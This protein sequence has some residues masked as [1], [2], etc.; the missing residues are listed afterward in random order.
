MESLG[1][2][3]ARI[4]G[5]T[6]TKPQIRT[7]LGQ[8][9]YCRHL[10]WA[11]TQPPANVHSQHWTL[12]ACHGPAVPVALETKLSTTALLPACPASAFALLQS[13]GE[14]LL[15]GT[16]QVVDP[17]LSCRSSLRKPK[18]GPQISRSNNWS[19]SLRNYAALTSSVSCHPAPF[20]LMTK[21]C[22]KLLPTC[23][24]LLSGSCPLP[25]WSHR[26]CPLTV[27][28]ST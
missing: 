18:S 10:S 28:S 5:S 21:P 8:G 1:W 12:G 9:R 24:H 15:V 26:V 11:L 25:C 17:Q 27:S 3:R 4:S 13:S 14:P 23:Q 16:V 6:R 19:P 7:E 22:D 20:G 2:C